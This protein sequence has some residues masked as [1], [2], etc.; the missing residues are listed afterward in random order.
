MDGFRL[1]SLDVSSAFEGRRGGRRGRPLDK[2]SLP[3]SSLEVCRER[4]MSALLEEEE[5]SAWLS[6][7]VD[8]DKFEFIRDDP[9]GAWALAEVV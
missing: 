5:S 4:E 3:A 9:A 1:L 2:L 7:R 6:P 8:R